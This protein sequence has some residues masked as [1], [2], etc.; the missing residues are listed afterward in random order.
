MAIKKIKAS[1]SGQLGTYLDTSHLSKEKLPK[2]LLIKKNQKSGRNAHGHITIRHRGGGSKKFIRKVDFSSLDKIDI[3]GKVDSFHYDPNRSAY[4]TLVIYRDGDKRLILAP[5]NLKIGDEIVC[6]SKAKPNIGNRLKL[7]NIPIGFN[8][9]NLELYASRGGQL[10]R[11]AGNS[12]KL[13]SLDGDMAQ[14]ELPSK[15]VRLFHKD[16]YATI[17]IIANEDHSLIRIGKA[18]RSRWMGKRPEVRGKVMNPCDHPHGGGEGR[19]PIG[20]KA[21]K[22]P[23]GALALGVKTRAKKK[24]SNKF[25]VKRRRRKK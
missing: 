4:L 18:G 19:C 1:T 17:G 9:H 15:E 20:M 14:V 2:N 12:G 10:I 21:P 13:V 5:K 3:I 16:C 24:P 7:E 25:I 8:I 11:S 22:T 23:W 6:Q